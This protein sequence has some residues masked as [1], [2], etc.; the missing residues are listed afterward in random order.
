MSL[1]SK[2]NEAEL[3]GTD[4]K[5][6]MAAFFIG[7]IIIVAI[8]LLYFLFGF[9]KRYFTVEY[10]KNGMMFLYSPKDGKVAK[11]ETNDKTPDFKGWDNV[12][13]YDNGKTALLSSK[14]S[15]NTLKLGYYDGKEI[16]NIADSC[17]DAAMAGGYCIYES[18]GKIYFSNIKNKPVYMGISGLLS[19]TVKISPDGRFILLISGENRQLNVFTLDIT[20]KTISG[21]N[22]LIDNV[23]TASFSGRKHDIG[24]IDNNNDFYFSSDGYTSKSDENVS[25]LTSGSDTMAFYYLKNND[26]VMRYN[27]GKKKEIVSGVKDFAYLGSNDICVLKDFNGGKGNL[28][29][30]NG[31]EMKL[32][33]SGVS[34]IK[35]GN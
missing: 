22:K 7:L 29:S 17:T 15:D 6:R 11:F 5:I 18:G 28:Y 2:K 25:D 13:L 34:S 8:A 10:E 1:L 23:K 21:G 9:G 33:D 16:K 4:K 24:F 26:T 20:E 30:Y 14:N 19:E 27:E 12:K 32:I 31:K 3:T 35:K